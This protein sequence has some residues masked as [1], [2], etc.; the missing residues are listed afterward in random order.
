MAPRLARL[1]EVALLRDEPVAPA[2][3]GAFEVV[4]EEAG[5]DAERERIRIGQVERIEVV[6]IHGCSM[7]G[8]RDTYAVISAARCASLGGVR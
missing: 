2:V 4:I 7:D 1:A 8:S 5:G 6:V 3:A